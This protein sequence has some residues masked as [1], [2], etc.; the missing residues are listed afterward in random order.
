MLTLT[1]N[2]GFVPIIVGLLMLAAPRM[3]RAPMMAGAALLALW[4]LLDREF[5]AATA[6]AQMGLPVVLLSLDA[7]NRI[8]GIGMLIVLIAL[9]IYTNARR[10]RY[11]D[12]AIMML[13][14]GSV[15]TL[16]VGDPISFVAAAALAGLA[17]AWTVFAAPQEHGNRAGVRLL[18]WHGLEGLL[19]LVGV[20]LHLTA[21]AGNSAWGQL[22][23]GSFGGACIFAALMIRVGAPMAHVWFKDVVSH[24]SPAGGAALSAF[25]TTVGLYALARHFP[26]EPLLV[27]IG[28]A[29]IVVGAFYASAEDDLRRAAAYAQMAQNGVCVALIGVGSPLSLAAA[30]GHAFT[31]LLAF[32]A[33]QMTLGGVLERGGA[34][35]VTQLAGTARAMP[36]S[37]FLMLGA[38]L[39]ASAAPLFAMYA[40]QSVAL[41]ATA[42]WD[43]RVL[44]AL[45]AVL[46]PVLFIALALRP[47]LAANQP[48][49]PPPSRNEAPFMM[50]LGAG[51]VIFL[52][53]S[54]GLAPRWLYDLMPAELA[55]QPYSIDRLAPQVAMLGVAGLAY[56]ALRFTSVA[57]RRQPARILD[58]DALY[59][60]PVAN[61][62]RWAG[63]VLL[64][65]YGAWQGATAAASRAAVAQMGLWARACDLPFRFTGMANLA[66]MVSIAA[67]LVIILLFVKVRG[68]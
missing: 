33:L 16:F 67:V 55:F 13:A 35:R 20:A 56:M 2:P 31:T 62:G 65:F 38:G 59:R 41:D 26:A 60:G 53:L 4:L 8:F 34:M 12:A 40:T 3:A 58:L 54:V 68:A 63:V 45:I 17:A 14:G 44:W 48:I 25:T 36:L 27:P 32:A 52:S 57:P 47:T 43:L 6:M 5:G 28:A 19:F 15:S 21:N 23:A 42:T 39:A 10:N 37:A 1:L 22:N 24:A 30:E 64:R 11:E 18:I 29:M 61:A 66:Q 9:A 7:L 46:P 50:L 51:L 49:A